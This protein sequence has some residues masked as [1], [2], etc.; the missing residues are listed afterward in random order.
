MTDTLET[1]AR[2]APPL[3]I[4]DLVATLTDA[5]PR[6]AEAY[7]RMCQAWNVEPPAK[8]DILVALGNKNLKEIIAE[9]TPSLPA[10]RIGE[11][12]Q[13]CNDTCD[14]LL[15]N[16]HWHE[17]IYPY[18]REALAA[19]SGQGYILGIYTGTRKEVLDSQLRYHNIVQYF[20]QRFVRGKNNE[21]D[22]FMPSDTLK[23][24]Q[25]QSII[26]SYATAF[27]IGQNEARASVLVAGD[28]IADFRAARQAGLSFVGFAIGESAR[29]NF[30]DID[31][32]IPIFSNFQHFYDLIAP[33]TS[34]PR[35]K[36]S[37]LSL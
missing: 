17:D 16:I 34:A 23:A 3:V 35:P 30:H 24:A 26:E 22:G 2:K 12:M 37:G 25:L 21:R 36:H 33:S 10:D 8:S 28:S 19:L 14:A 32:S 7:I 6:Y 4:F 5:G 11:F 31:S 1:I 9:F 27:G 20:D 15:Y 29:K 18:V 13:G